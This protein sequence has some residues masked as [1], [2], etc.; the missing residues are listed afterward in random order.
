V[1]GAHTD[2][3]KRTLRRQ[4]DQG[5]PV[6]PRISIPAGA[7]A[8]PENLTGGSACEVFALEPI[9]KRPGSRSDLVGNE[10]GC[11][12]VSKFLT[13]AADDHMIKNFILD[14]SGT[15]VDDLD[16]VIK[17]TNSV[18]KD[19]GR[20]TV[21]EEEYRREFALPFAKFYG[22]F[23]PGIPLAQIN[24][25]YHQFYAHYRDQIA[26]LPGVGEFCEF[27]TTTGL[28]LYV[29]STIEEAHFEYQA[30]RHGIRPFFT[31]AYVGVVD[32]AKAIPSLL[33]ENDLSPAETLFVGDSVHD[34]EAA[35][36]GGV[37]AVA[38]LTGFDTVEKLAACKPDLIIRDFGSLQRVL[39][40]AGKNCS[41]EWIEIADLEV[42]SKIGVSEKERECFQRL[43]VC[44]RFQIQ[45]SFRELNDEFEKTVDYA[46][47]AA[48]VK[49][50]AEANKA[51]LLETLV[52]EIADNLME[53]FPM[54]RLKLELKK[55][56][57]PNVR[58]V[59]VKAER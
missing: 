21:T 5:A 49:E 24:A 30:T 35:R 27:S 6:S 7:N 18:L 38:V 20:S 17:A 8:E 15:V 23:L 25:V 3:V 44:L 32:K 58:C 19:F 4:A 39:E 57:L 55:F 10:M 52:S 53:R 54:R 14:W 1:E 59:S 22:R 41:D 46:G 37:M 12:L 33:A 43:L 9:G 51:Q 40:A 2:K 56:I 11:G 50:V 13:N 42:K 28:R 47:V 45:A 26:L 48:A 34:M 16:A 29:L 31:R 36:H